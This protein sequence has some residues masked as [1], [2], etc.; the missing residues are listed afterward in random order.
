MSNKNNEFFIGWSDKMPSSYAQAVKKMVVLLIPIVLLVAFLV[1]KAQKDFSTSNFEYGTTT[2]LE[3]TLI[4]TPAPMLRINWGMDLD[5]KP[6][7]QHILLVGFGKLGAQRTLTKIENKIGHDLNG[8]PVI[9]AG[10][11]IYHDGK[12]TLELTDGIAAY[13]GASNKLANSTISTIPLG[14]LNLQGEIIDPKCFFGVMKPGDGKPHKSCAARCISGGIP[15]IFVTR[16]LN[17]E[18]DYYLLVG[19]NGEAINQEILPF[20]ADQLRITGQANQMHDWKIL[21]L[22]TTKDIC[23]LGPKWIF[24]DMEMCAKL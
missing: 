20:V 14:T 2:V 19:E 6:V 10:T 11:L 4:K 17:G 5:E 16:K 24:A 12:T 22:A 18:R 23:R 15:P 3:G 21:S 13:K 9:L 8:K 7:F 1:V